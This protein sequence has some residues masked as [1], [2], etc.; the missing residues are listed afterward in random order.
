MNPW[1][2]LDP[3]DLGDALLD[4]QIIGEDGTSVGKVDDLE[5]RRA[6]DHYV[7]DALL[8]GSVALSDRFDGWLSALLRRLGRWFRTE[9]IQRIPMSAI[10][11]AE[12]TIVVTAAV[13]RETYSPAEEWLRRKVIGR[14]PGADHASK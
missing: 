13:A 7:V 12:P 10:R 1:E 6:G 8:I 2:G 5:L 14:I 11:Q 3:V 9:Q 4:R